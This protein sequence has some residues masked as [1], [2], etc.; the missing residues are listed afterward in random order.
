MRSG[1]TAICDAEIR[2]GLRVA[3][4]VAGLTAA[5]CRERGEGVSNGPTDI[6]GV[7]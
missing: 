3:G 1:G 4:T 2:R 7:R 5:E 6:F